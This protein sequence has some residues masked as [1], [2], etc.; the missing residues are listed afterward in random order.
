ME[1]NKNEREISASLKNND[2]GDAANPAA[3]LDKR[4][5]ESVPQKKG[6]FAFICAYWHVFALF[7]IILV[8]TVN[9]AW[10]ILNDRSPVVADMAEHL[11]YARNTY[12]ILFELPG[13]KNILIFSNAYEPIVHYSAAIAMKLFGISIP[14]ALWSLFP[15]SI[16]MILS[17]YGTGKHF[18]GKTGGIAAALIGT[19]NC[20]FIDYSHL[21]MQ[22]IAHAALTCLGFYL[23]LKTDG[24]RKPLL[25][26]GFGVVLGLSLLARFG[27]IFYLIAPIAIMFIYVCFRSIRILVPALLA[28][29]V[30][31]YMERH[32]FLTGVMLAKTHTAPETYIF[33]QFKLLMI[34]CVCLLAA[35]I[36]FTIFKKQ[37]FGEKQSDNAGR[38]INILGSTMAAIVVSQPW[39]LVSS[40]ILFVR[41]L[42]HTGGHP[43]TDID[44]IK[45]NLLLNLSTLNNF[46]PLIFVLAFI[47][48]VFAVVKRIKLLD[49]FM[50]LSMGIV[51]FLLSSLSASPFSRYF[52][53]DVMVLA[54]LGGYW[55]SYAG[56]LRLP[57]VAYISAYSALMLFYP[58]FSP[59][60]PGFWEVYQVK[61]NKLFYFEPVYA[62][63]P[64]PDSY[65]LYALSDDIKA[66]LAR[67]GDT[68]DYYLLLQLSPDFARLDKYPGNNAGMMSERSLMDLYGRNLIRVLWFR[69]MPFSEDGIMENL[70]AGDYLNSRRDKPVVLV[71]GYEKPE[72]ADDLVNRIE[73]EY[74]RKVEKISAYCVMD[75]KKVNVYLVYPV[76]PEGI[77]R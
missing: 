7:L 49:M 27:S 4:T 33:S 13:A 70:N 2:S 11:P 56:Y 69:G 1:L 54:V 25:S 3:S 22:D 21:Y 71:A 31:V 59:Y 47:G 63:N 55:V 43:L 39:Y 64:T 44:F 38:F 6:F 26:W 32:F 37:I 45:M 28:A 41:F 66:A 30:V 18:G 8:F 61:E 17:I 60:V 76:Y 42:W 52:L 75:K 73:S 29:G 40:G 51:G 9:N 72:F 74:N 58:F 53:V 36:V 23:L 62:A 19:A 50:L 65:K 12:R 10:F 46:F 68:S 77:S 67:A 5:P 34:V 57:A 15:F 24:F 48:L 14:V 20:Y 35:I 16:I